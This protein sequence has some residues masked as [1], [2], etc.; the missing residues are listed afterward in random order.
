MERLKAQFTNSIAAL[1]PMECGRLHC[2]VIIQ[3][4]EPHYYVA[5]ANPTSSGYRLCEKCYIYYQKNPYTVTSVMPV[6]NPVPD[7][8]AICQD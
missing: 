6:E 5:S 3:S 7:A 4:G 1:T 2:K 8:Q